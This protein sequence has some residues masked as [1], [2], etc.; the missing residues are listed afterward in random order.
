MNRDALLIIDDD[1]DFRELVRLCVTA[2][3]MEV[4]DAADCV[5]GIAV[6]REARDRVGIVL[7]DYWMPNMEPV[8]CAKRILELVQPSAR[9][10]LVTAAVD[11]KVR[12]AELGISEWLSKP[13][14]L[15]CLRS[16]VVE[17]RL[18][19]ASL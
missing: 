16:I 1:Q 6:L 18:S 19:V 9:V 13:F 10:L 5:D 15:D 7:L 2:E 8:R 12:A 4:L 11:A 3:G 14:E 17:T